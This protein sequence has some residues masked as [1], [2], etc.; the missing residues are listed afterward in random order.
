MTVPYGFRLVGDVFNRRRLVDW[1]AALRA[2]ASCDARAALDTPAYL[3]AYCY[4]A[5]FAAHLDA[6][7]TP[8]GYAGAAAAPFIW[9]DLDAADLD[10]SLASARKLAGTLLDRYRSL[11]DDGLLLA[12]SGSKG[13]HVGL[14][15]GDLAGP[16][17]A[18]P[19]VVRR[20]AEAAA[21]RA[22]ATI[23]VSI[24][25]RIRPFRAPN[26]R[27]QKTGLH[28][29]RLALDELLALPSARIVELAREP[30]PFDLPAP[31]DDSTL[32][33]DWQMA[34]DEASQS[35]A[36][37]RSNGMPGRLQ[38]ETLDFIRDGADLGSRHPRLFRAAAN[39]A[40]FGCPPAL[41]H[42]LLTPAGLDSGLPPGEVRRQIDC[43]LA[44][45]GRSVPNLENLHPRE[46]ATA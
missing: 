37:R 12:F 3:S 21:R 28:K 30:M 35:A 26:S 38:R 7:G 17:V 40:E 43:G 13:F 41:A 15:V 18:T 46:K 1:W 5:D 16:A 25:D 33:A 31:C 4:P 45:A 10:E 20:F 24:Y 36:V 6:N 9:F 22:G 34:S 32:L 39:L 19:A 2:Y 14:P 27:H 11:D 42:E 23:D 29:R 8:K 44:H